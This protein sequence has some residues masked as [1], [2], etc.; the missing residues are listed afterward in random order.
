MILRILQ[1]IAVGLLLA[2]CRVRDVRT[3]EIQVPK[4]H[5]QAC[6]DVIQKAVSGILPEPGAVK[7]DL[8]RR[9]V[10]ATYDSLVM[11]RKNIEFVIADVGFSANDIPANKD[12]E[13]RLPEACKVS[14][15]AP[16]SE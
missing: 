1:V 4:M 16:V 6:V 11:A 7:I 9:V 8:E 15:V 5:N 14:T 10:T 2:G 3:F 12:A 13:A